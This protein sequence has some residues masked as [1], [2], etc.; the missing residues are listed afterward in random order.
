MRPP[1]L[2]LH[3]GFRLEFSTLILAPQ[4]NKTMDRP[5][6]PG[7]WATQH[8]ASCD[9]QRLL[10]F[11]HSNC[12]CVHRMLSL[13]NPN[14][15]RDL[16]LIQIY[17]TFVIWNRNWL[18]ILLPTVLFVANSGERFWH[19][20]RHPDILASSDMLR[21]SGSSIWLTLALSTVNT[22][23][24]QDITVKILTVVD[25]FLSLTLCTN[26]ICTGQLF[27]SAIP[28]QIAQFIW[29]A[30]PHLIPYLVYS[31]PGCTDNGLERSTHSEGCL[32]Y[33][34]IW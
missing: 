8:A 25:L 27:V 23:E 6:R 3:C 34:R 31:S 32:Y 29:I 12:R 22:A 16:T 13:T 10:V 18:I 17:R 14:L 28:R 4:R 20:L 7:L 15:T 21:V 30:R 19:S 24:R 5:P 9:I 33:H 11:P 26:V 2:P 1:D